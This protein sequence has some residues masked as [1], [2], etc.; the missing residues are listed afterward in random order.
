MNERVALY[1]ASLYDCAVEENSSKEV[2]ESLMAVLKAVEKNPEYVR[3]MNSVVLTHAEKESLVEEAFSGQI[4]EFALNF[5]KILAKKRIFDI[6][7]PCIKEYEKKYLKDNNIQNATIITAIELDDEK[8]NAIVEKISKSS[9]KR[10]NATFKV[11]EC[12]LGGIIIET[13]NSGI[14]ASVKT[15]LA[16]IGRHISK[17]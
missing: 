6:L 12:I 7:I 5:I 10:V 14:D 1:T 13:D 11:D 15:K 3:I 8:K 16:E 2:Y 9:G 4:H 17:N